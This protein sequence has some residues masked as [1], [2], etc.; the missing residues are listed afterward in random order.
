[1]SGDPNLILF[2]LHFVLFILLGLSPGTMLAKLT[3]TSNSVC[4]YG[5]LSNIDEIKVSY[6]HC[7]K[8]SPVDSVQFSIIKDYNAISKIL[9][10]TV[11]SDGK[12]FNCW[13]PVLGAFN[14]ATIQVTKYGS[15]EEN[16]ITE[17]RKFPEIS[18][19]TD[20]KG[21]LFVNGRELTIQHGHCAT[22]VSEDFVSV[23][24]SC[25]SKAT[26]C[27]IQL[28]SSVNNETF[29][30]E[31]VIYYQTQTFPSILV[32]NVKYAACLLDKEVNHFKCLIAVKRNI[33]RKHTFTFTALS[34]VD[35]YS[36][37]SRTS[38]SVC[39]SG[40]LN[41]IDMIHLTCIV[42]CCLNIDGEHTM[43]FALINE[44]EYKPNPWPLFIDKEC[45]PSND[46]CYLNGDN[47]V[48]S[49]KI[50]A[51]KNFNDAYLRCSLNKWEGMQSYHLPKIYDI[52]D[53]Q[54]KL[55]IN[56]KQISLNKQCETE[57]SNQFLSMIFLC[58]SKA[59]PCL[60]EIST[61]NT[62]EI[63]N[64]M[65]VFNES[66]T[67]SSELILTIKFAACR[68]DKEFHQISCSIKVNID[69]T[70]SSVPI[71]L[72]IV[73]T[74]LIS[75]VAFLLGVTTIVLHI[76]SRLFS[77]LLGRILHCVKRR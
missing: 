6:H 54:G 11:S 43:E 63:F 33:C 58:E 14:G 25:E 1:M 74:S 18:D 3:M 15:K 46:V 22:E 10:H 68:L 56:G 35:F 28:S 57:V 40:V 12:S 30:G 31:N 77:G 48:F 52:K 29:G 51:N 55:F 70:I 66:Y 49:R 16:E 4:K 69:N 59:T 50:L 41:N 47:I 61:N 64:N 8:T 53:A 19:V 9:R 71:W 65:A 27:M 24:F 67:D 34:D 72:S 32:L 76:K 2:K 7:N 60:I 13:I 17:Y 44:K 45:I 5:L 75:V 62:K 36:M 38:D 20:A 21:R 37:H 42:P 73:I 26:P 39:K 23:I